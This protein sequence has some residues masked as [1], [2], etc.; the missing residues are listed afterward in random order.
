MTQKAKDIFKIVAVSLLALVVIVGNV[1]LFIVLGWQGYG[2]YALGL[3]FLTIRDFV[4]TKKASDRKKESFDA[5]DQWFRWIYDDI[6]LWNIGGMIGAGLSSEVFMPIVLKYWEWPELA[7]ISLDNT[8]ILICT[9]MG[10]KTLERF[11]NGKLKK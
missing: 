8:A 1:G 9:I 4:Q 3:A 2:F 7:E 5:Y 11:I 6:L 10:A